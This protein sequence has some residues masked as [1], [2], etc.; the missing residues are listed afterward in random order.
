MNPEATKSKS[1]RRYDGTRRKERARQQRDAT[2]DVARELFMREGYVATTVESVA[3]A[4]GVSPATIY[5]TYGGKSGLVRELCARS[6]LGD[7]TVHAHRRSD[8]LRA[9]SSA[10][11]VVTGWGALV[12]EVSPHISPLLLL[13]RTAAAFDAE[14]AALGDE[15][16]AENLER[17]GDNA[18]Y[19]IDTGELRDGI[20]FDEVRDVLWLCSSPEL[21]DML[22]TRR[23]WSNEQFGRFVADTISWSVFERPPGS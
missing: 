9:S 17:M 2:L 1:G 7:G 10:R 21:Y 11:E 19:L 5:K 3:H 23:G 20:S 14:A 16:E 18:Q 6:F 4:A 8:A 22:I 12:A 13:L 15:L